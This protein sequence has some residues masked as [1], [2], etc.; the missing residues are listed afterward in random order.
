MKHSGSST[1]IIMHKYFYHQRKIEESVIL[2]FTAVSYLLLLFFLSLLLF[3]SY[4]LL[5]QKH[6][7]YKNDNKIL[8]TNQ[9][10]DKLFQRVQ[11]QQVCSISAEDICISLIS[12]ILFQ[13]QRH[14]QQR[15][16]LANGIR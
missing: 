16:S 7:L 15:M 8:R 11:Q 1:S 9:L 13:Q 4:S 2:N 10:K 12:S 3:F 5:L 6:R 14:I